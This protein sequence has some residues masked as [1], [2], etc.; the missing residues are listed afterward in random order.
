V[1]E[2]L[3]DAE[4]LVVGGAGVGAFEVL[5]ANCRCPTCAGPGPLICVRVKTASKKS[6]WARPAGDAPAVDVAQSANAK[7]A[8]G[9]R[10]VLRMRAMESPRV[11]PKL[12]E[13]GRRYG[14]GG[15]I[16]SGASLS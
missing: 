11:E 3:D 9:K 1:G 8:V 16:A 10:T 4:V 13:P 12:T 15:S 14:R 6:A 5:L 2:H 7:N